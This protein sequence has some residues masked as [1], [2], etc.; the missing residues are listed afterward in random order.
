[1]TTL[2]DSNGRPRVVITGMG[3]KT[4]AGVRRPILLFVFSVNQRLPSAPTVMP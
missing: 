2:I 4:P 3:V 1:M